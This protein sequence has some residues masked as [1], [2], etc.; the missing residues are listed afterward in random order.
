MVILIHE[1]HLYSFANV[2]RLYMLHIFR[3]PYQCETD[4]VNHT[5][6]DS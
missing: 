6:T 4:N 2:Q 5:D 1:R 3:F